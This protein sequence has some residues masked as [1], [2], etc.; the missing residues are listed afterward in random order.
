MSSNA[1]APSGLTSLISA[2]ST[3]SAAQQVNQLAGSPLLNLNNYVLTNLGPNTIYV[4]IANGTSDVSNGTPSPALVAT[5]PVAGTPANG[6][7]VLAGSKESIT[8]TAG[9]WFS[10]VC[11]STQTATLLITQGE[12][13]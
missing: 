13:V 12:G 11:A 8:A 6:Y 9:A 3:A 1:F 4:A 7:P 2:T 10:A 5:I